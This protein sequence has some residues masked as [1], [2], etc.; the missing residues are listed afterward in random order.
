MAED[1]NNDAKQMDKKEAKRQAKIEAKRRKLAEQRASREAN[2]AGQEKTG[3]SPA[4]ADDAVSENSA[5]AGGR[6]VVADSNNRERRILVDK[7]ESGAAPED[8]WETP[9]EDKETGASE[10]EE[11]EVKPVP[12]APAAA[13]ALRSEAREK[14]HAGQSIFSKIGKTIV[15]FL[16]W[17]F[18][19][20]WNGLKNMTPAMAVRLL[21]ALV[22]LIGLIYGALELADYYDKKTDI[23]VTDE[24]F[25][26]AEELESCVPLNGIDISVHQEGEIDWKKVKTS[27]VDFVF[28][29][30]GYR[31]ADDGS[32][33]ADESFAKN[34]K[35]AKKAGLMVGTYF[36]SQALTPEE[37]KEE[38]E[39]VLDIIDGYDLT[40]PVAIDYEIYPE[41][42]LDKKIQAGDL[43]AASFY[44]DIVLG[45]TER[46]EKE[47]YE[48]VVYANRDMLTNYMQADLIDDMA[49]IW[50]ARFDTMANLDAD[51]WFWQCSEE[52]SVGGIE[53]NVDKNFWYMQPEKVYETRGK[54]GK[55]A[56]SIGDCR[57]SFKRSS[58]KLHN[59]RAEPKYAMTYDG[60]GMKEGRDYV[61]TLV[62]NTQPGTGYI[63]IRGID[64]YKDWVMYPFKIDE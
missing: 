6:Q 24:G 3:E 20:I 52:G 53:G 5:K 25:F 28:I 56:I 21:V 43:Y 63:I 16:K 38:A 42:R 36:Y 32:L 31:A 10:P 45:F 26:H 13:A 37:G 35:G 11:A 40:M 14:K 15:R 50:L 57:I 41:G 17:L 47:G 61:S 18:K 27:G 33:H 51:Y 12:A 39:F 30:S 59:F 64:K 54:R 55:K 8:E 62:H 4:A 49:N 46:I 2:T 44:H 22:V 34:F 60:K 9:P 29:R 48:T 1:N 7:Y 23:R 19:K 58:F